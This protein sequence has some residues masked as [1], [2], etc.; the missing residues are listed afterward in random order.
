[1]KTRLVRIGASL[2][3]RIPERLIKK[4]GL[5]DE[6]DIRVHAGGLIVTPVASLRAGWA[7]AAARYAKRDAE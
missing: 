6:V 4:A 7:E 1:M 2:G 3:V 5:E